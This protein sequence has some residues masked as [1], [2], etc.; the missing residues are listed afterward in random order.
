MNRL[1]AVAITMIALLNGAS[2]GIIETLLGKYGRFEEQV[3]EET[4]NGQFHHAIA[5]AMDMS[6][7]RDRVPRCDK[8]RKNVDFCVDEMNFSKCINCIMAVVDAGTKMTNCTSAHSYYCGDETGTVA[9]CAVEGQ[10]GEECADDLKTLVSCSLT[11][12]N[13]DACPSDL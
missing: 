6:T 13:C 4:A 9:Q 3:A 2:A 11:T 10:C 8:E 1:L 12:D 7:D 5:E